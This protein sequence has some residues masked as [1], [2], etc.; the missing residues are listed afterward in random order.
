MCTT[1]SR[2]LAALSLAALAVSSGC[3][4]ADGDAETGTVNINL[5]GQGTSGTVYRLRD[6]TIAVDGPAPTL[7]N[8]EDD[9]DRTALSANVPAGSYS[10]TLAPGWRLERLQPGMPPVDVTA[11]LTSPNPFAFTVVAMERT[12][13]PLRFAVE[14]DVVDMTSGYD[15]TIGVDDLGTNLVVSASNLTVLE[16]NTAVFNVRLASAPAVPV[17]VTVT[18]SDPSAVATTPTTLTFTPA[19]YATAQSVTAFAVPDADVAPEMVVISLQAPGLPTALV[20]VFVQ[21]VNMQGLVV[22]PATL[23]VVEGGTATFTVRLAAQPPANVVVNVASSDGSAV[24]A[25]PA[26]LVFT[27]A[28]WNVAQIVTLTGVQ[29]ADLVDEAATITLSSPFAPSAAVAVT[30]TDDDVQSIQVNVTSVTLVEGGTASIGVR[31]GAQPAA[32]VTVQIVSSD[33]G[34]VVV[35]P[36]TITFT[37][38]NWATFQTVTLTAPQDADLLDETVSLQLVAPGTAPANVSVSVVDND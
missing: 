20:T 25:T 7:W 27:P 34:A 16:G 10:A 38:A 24:T 5:V 22:T 33:V 32:T 13:V 30:V 9:P 31:L 28:S 23:S 2:A 11:S 8:T 36:A 21:D 18:A 15:I 37:P 19:N 6:A 12:A 17:T 3:I 35:S 14:G 29:D 1:A 4:D 26:M